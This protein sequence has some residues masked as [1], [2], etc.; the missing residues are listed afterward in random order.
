MPKWWKWFSWICPIAW[1][2]Y[3]LIASQ[4]GDVDDKYLDDPQQTVKK[5]IDDYLGFKHDHVGLAAFA[6]VAVAVLFAL[7]F[8]FSIKSFNFQ[9]R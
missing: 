7:I 5:F 4:F 6:V 8:A 2:L 1:T 3:G 9:K